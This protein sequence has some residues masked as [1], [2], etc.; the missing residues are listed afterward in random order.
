MTTLNPLDEKLIHRLGEDA[1]QSSETLAKQLNISPATVRRRLRKLI[2]SGIIRVVAVADP[3]KAGFPL[4]AAITFDIAHEKLEVAVQKLAGYS[5]IK[6]VATTT[7][8]F[9]VLAL[10]TFRST[11]ELS[12]FVQRELVKIEGL[13]DT[14]TSICLQVKKGR[15][16]NL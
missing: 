3:V 11:E 6:W 15:Y 9:D 16:I 12:D 13:R 7:G 8:R 2:R 5:A 1:R 14:E 4:T 10:A